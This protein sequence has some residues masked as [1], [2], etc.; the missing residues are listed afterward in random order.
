MNYPTKCSGRLITRRSRKIVTNF[1]RISIGAKWR[2]NGKSST[3]GSYSIVVSSSPRSLQGVKENVADLQQRLQQY[4]KKNDEMHEKTATLERKVKIIP[5]L[6]TSYEPGVYFCSSE[7]PNSSATSTAKRSSIRTP[8]F[9][10][11]R[12]PPNV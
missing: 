1:A 10:C 9:F 6:L 2:T 8:T 4:Q 5:R 3:N 7:N 12:P 11:S